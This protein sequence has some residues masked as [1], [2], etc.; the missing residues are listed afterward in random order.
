MN[1]DIINAETVR[2]RLPMSDCIE[3]MAEAMRAVAKRSVVAPQRINMQLVDGTGH[4]FLMP[5]SSASPRVYGAKL[6][7]LHPGNPAAGRP[8]VQ[9]FVTLFDHATGTPVALV[10]GG[11]ITALRTAAMSG[12]ATRLL[13]RPNARSMGVLGCGVQATAHIDAVTSVRTIEEIRVWG[14]SA[15]SAHAFVDKHSAATSAR[16]VA[17]AAAEE[18]AQ[19]DVVCVVT[20]ASEPVIRG[21]WLRPGTH[22]NLVGAHSPKSREAD[23]QLVAQSRIYVDS[24]DAALSEAGDLIIPIAEG[25]LARDDIVGE[26][27]ALLLKRIPG[28]SNTSEITVFKSVGLAVEDILAAHAVYMRGP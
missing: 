27:G 23:T 15:K 16:I 7:S 19:C 24:V 14:R 5:V 28:R 26:I 12:L 25:A 21:A 10:D 3:V 11:A 17:V 13:A 8:A 6:V 22:V 1:L 9:G 4:V 20:G 18:A 2:A